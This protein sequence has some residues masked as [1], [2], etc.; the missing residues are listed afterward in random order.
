MI[1]AGTKSVIE[2]AK[3]IYRERLETVLSDREANRFVAIEP[4]SGDYFLGDLK[5]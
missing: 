3:R 1:S 5:L 4:E 2:R